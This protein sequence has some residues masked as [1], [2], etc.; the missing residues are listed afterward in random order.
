M[1][2]VVLCA[3]TVFMVLASPVFAKDGLYI[4]AYALPKTKVSG[5]TGIGSG[6][7]YGF[8]AGF[9]FSRYFSIEGSYELAEQDMTNTLKADLKGW[10]ADAKIN[11]PLTSLERGDVIAV[12]PYIRGG[13]GDYELKIPGSGSPSGNGNR[14]GAGVEIYL[15]RELSINAGWTR[16]K[17]SLDTPFVKTDAR[18]KAI[19]VGLNYH[20]L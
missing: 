3:V 20:F 10:A 6:S 5:V 9:G 17:V 1:N 19:D 15:F 12:E 2:K 14:F 16:T 8:R 4:G 11:F 13:Y 18:I 7:G